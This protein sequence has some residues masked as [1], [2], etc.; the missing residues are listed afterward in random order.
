MLDQTPRDS[1]GDSGIWQH[2]QSPSLPVADLADA[3]SARRATTSRPTCCCGRSASRR[4]A[5]APSRSACTRTALLDLVRDNRGPDDAPQ[6][7]VGSAAEL[8]WLFAALARGEIVEPQLSQRVLGWLSLNSDLSMVASAFGLDPLVAPRPDHGV[9]LDEQ[10]RHR[11]RRA[12]RGRRAPRPARRASPTRCRCSSPTR[13]SPSR[14]AVLDA[15]APGRARP[16]RVRALSGCRELAASVVTAFA[17]SLS[18]AMPSRTASRVSGAPSTRK[19]PAT[20]TR[21]F[22]APSS[23]LPSGTCASNVPNT[24]TMRAFTDAALPSITIVS[25]PGSRA[26]MLGSVNRRAR[27]APENGV[28]IATSPRRPSASASSRSS[29]CLPT[30]PPLLCATMIRPAGRTRT[31]ASARASRSEVSTIGRRFRSQAVHDRHAVALR[32]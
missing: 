32:R 22:V 19:C 9:L 14:L 7:S 31:R 20:G 6:L 10:D 27:R 26:R 4:C 30:R 21:T 17:A 18:R 1:V 3:R 24:D 16:A 11:R 5:R 25:S 2:L 15:H 13:C 8:T 23:A 28:Q 29:R 12:Q